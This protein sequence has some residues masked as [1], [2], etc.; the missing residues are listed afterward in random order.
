MDEGFRDARRESIEMRAELRSEI[1]EAR[2]ESNERYKELRTE[3]RW[4]V[5]IQFT[6]LLAVLGLL[7]RAVNLF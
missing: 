4:V 1:R 2:N 3:M 7:A 6:T 5:G